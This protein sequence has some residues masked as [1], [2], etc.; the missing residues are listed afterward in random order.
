MFDPAQLADFH[1]LRPW[2]LL[3]AVPLLVSYVVMK[4]RRDGTARWRGV[5]AP[6]L[7]DA[8]I[9]KKQSGR[10]IEPLNMSMLCTLLLSIALAG[11]TWERAPSPFAEDEA[12]LVIALD[13]STSMNQSDVQPTRLERA[14]QKIQDL[15]ALRKGSRTALIAYAGSAHGVIPLTNDPDIINNLLDAVET[16]IMPLPGKFPEK[17]LPVA[18]EIFRASP[19]PGTLLLMTDGSGVGSEAAFREYFSTRK[20][21]LLVWGIG[22]ETWDPPE[23]APADYLPL[24]SDA[25]RDLAAAGDGHFQPLTIDKSDARRLFFRTE[26]YLSLVDDEARPWLDG[27]YYLLLPAMLIALFWFRKGWTLHWLFLLALLP[28]AS[29]PAVAGNGF[30]DWWLTPD[31]QGRYYFEK[32]EY[33]TAA[34][35]FRDPVWKAVAHY[36]AENFTAATDLF[37]RIETADGFFNLG[38]AWA[39]AQ[40]YLN[41]VAAYDR[42]LA[43]DP[44]HA[45]AR[46]NRE[47]IQK[48]I[49][50]IN[51]FSEN[52]QAEAGE[53]TKELGEDDPKRA[54][55][56]EK[57]SFGK[58]EIKQYNADEILNNPE[59]NELWMRQ[60][61][62][63][64]SR[65]LSLKFQLQLQRREAKKEEP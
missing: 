56:A 31:Q 43:L 63:N 30:V 60:V 23:L 21:Q 42:A 18:D 14:R 5:I 64:P 32:G 33:Q 4:R 47:I 29:P 59:I 16:D 51:S 41:A 55:G 57:Q 12:V 54:E 13:A 38:N 35:R 61:Q 10:L 40:G 22:R 20:H 28:L 9:V 45:G 17:V 39:H 2:W 1:F 46:K 3:A 27:G 19:V 26:N 6:H 65:F 25:L 50:E 34:E 15:L 8:L 37:A 58:K 48:I 62:Q 36:H 7:L 53:D 52:Q 24:E 49:D 44:D 11:P